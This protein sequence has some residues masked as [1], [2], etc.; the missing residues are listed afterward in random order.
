M[1]H[2]SLDERYEKMRNAVGYIR[3]STEGQNQ[4]DRFGAENQ[5]S[6]IIKWAAEH[7]Y[8]IIKWYMDVAS[9]AKGGGEDDEEDRPGMYALLHDDDVSN[10]PYEAVIAYK[11][12]RIARKTQLFYYYYLLLEKKGIRLVCTDESFPEGSEYAFLIRTMMQFVA[13]Q[14]RKNIEMRTSGGRKVKAN[15]GGYA[16]GNIPYGYANVEGHF[17]INPNEAKV[18]KR[19]FE[20]DDIGLSLRKIASC[21][22]AD[23]IN[24]R[25]GDPI[26]HNNVRSILANRKTYE[27][28]YRYGNMEEWVKGDFEAIL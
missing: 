8:Q 19:I 23:G 17:Q 1:V 22:A 10:P 27:G 4:D 25:S 13:E 20:L 2:G 14:E 15:K 24:N 7:D 11:N 26:T 18:V 3:V 5:R 16:G 28:Y 21:L 9:G 12:D 6:A